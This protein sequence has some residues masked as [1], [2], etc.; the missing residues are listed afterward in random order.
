[1]RT[2]EERKGGGSEGWHWGWWPSW[3]PGLRLHIGEDPKAR[4]RPNPTVGGVQGTKEVLGQPRSPPVERTGGWGP[5][6][7]W[8]QV[9]HTCVPLRGRGKSRV[10]LPSLHTTMWLSQ[11][12]SL[13]VDPGSKSR[14]AQERSISLKVKLR[15]AALRRA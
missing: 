11:T 1:M 5:R 4:C 14:S 9:L 15:P 8:G 2:E 3:A 7:A 10:L 12:H 13:C 6:L